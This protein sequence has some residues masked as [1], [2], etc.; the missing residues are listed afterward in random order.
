M[1]PRMMSEVM[2]FDAIGAEVTRG[3]RSDGATALGVH[4]LTTHVLLPGE[5]FD[6]TGRKVI[7]EDP[8]PKR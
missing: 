2:V 8:W 7:A 5:V 1:P 4:D 6:V 3:P